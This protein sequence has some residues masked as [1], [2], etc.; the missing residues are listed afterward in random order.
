MAFSSYKLMECLQASEF[1][2][3]VL[4]ENGDFHSGKNT[5][6]RISFLTQ[7]AT[8]HLLVLFPKHMDPIL[9]Y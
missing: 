3:P 5:D 9:N 8:C 7:M 1:V 2:P 4:V 6:R